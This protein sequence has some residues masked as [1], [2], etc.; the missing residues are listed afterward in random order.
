[1]ARVS[2]A[3]GE[4]A[5]I[6]LIGARYGVAAD[7]GPVEL[8]IGDDAAL[9]NA[10]E[11]LAVVTTDLLVENTHFRMDLTEPYLLGWKSVAASLSDI[12]AMGAEPTCCFVSIGL[13]DVEVSLVESIYQGMQ[14]VSARYSSVIAGG[15]TVSSACG[16]VINVTQLGR[17]ERGR[18]ALRSGA[19]P[20][21][22]ILVTNTLGDSRAGLELLLSRGLEGARRTSS[23]LVERHLKPEPRVREAAAAVR[24]GGVTAMMDISDGLSADLSRLCAASGVGAR[25]TADALPVSAELASTAEI[26]GAD[27][28]EMAAGGGEDYELLIVS[29]PGAADGIARAIEACGSRASVIGETVSSGDVLLVHAD[30]REAPMPGGWRHF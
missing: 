17:A 2:E 15:D 23:Y 4:D 12:A 20:G 3:G 30:G 6:Q 16:I 27:R 28:V 18:A 10:G 9:L 1:M 19:G 25:L 11:Y 24:A 7:A 5:L 22:A 14:A 13:P 8:G 26:L 21:Q 29:E